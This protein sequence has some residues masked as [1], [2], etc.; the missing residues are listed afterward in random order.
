[1]SKE[2]QEIWGTP[3]TSSRIKS[4]DVKLE[5][6]PFSYFIGPFGALLSSG[7]FTSILQ[8]TLPTFSNWI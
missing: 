2:K 3:L 1:M 4:P 6:M 7:I 5:E 8:T